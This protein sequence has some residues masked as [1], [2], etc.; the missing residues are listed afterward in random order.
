MS[1]IVIVLLIGHPHNP[2]DL[3]PMP[4][5]HSS[6]LIVLWFLKRLKVRLVR[7]VTAGLPFAHVHLYFHT[8]LDPFDIPSTK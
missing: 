1:R 8:S 2:T 6:T 3:I 4:I 5:I 7:L